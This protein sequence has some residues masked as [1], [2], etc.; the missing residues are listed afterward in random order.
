MPA[1]SSRTNG[2]LATALDRARAAWRDCAARVDLILSCQA[3]G[4]PALA[5]SELSADH[6]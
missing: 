1:S 2:D 3:R 5:A 4:V 6:E